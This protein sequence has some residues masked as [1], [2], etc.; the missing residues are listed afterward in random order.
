M[1]IWPSS[2]HPHG[3]DNNLIKLKFKIQVKF[4][5]ETTEFR[6]G[7]WVSVFFIRALCLMCHPRATSWHATFLWLLRRLMGV[8]SPK[9]TK[10][11]LLR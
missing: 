1:I 11:I 8:I 6:A 7:T 9:Q 3:L 5:S 2:L 10:Q 4:C